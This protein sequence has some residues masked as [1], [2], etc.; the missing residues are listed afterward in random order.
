MYLSLRGLRRGQRKFHT[1]YGCFFG[2]K[3]CLLAI[4]KN[5]TLIM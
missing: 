4:V 1:I 2:I 5:S 3:A